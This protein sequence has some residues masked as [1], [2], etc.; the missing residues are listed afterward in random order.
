M[1]VRIRRPSQGA[2]FIHPSD[3]AARTAILA[4]GFRQTRLVRVFPQ[5]W[6]ERAKRFE[7]GSIAGPLEQLR[8]LARDGWPI[9]QAVVVFTYAGAPGISRPDR[10]CFWRVFGVPVFEQ[11]LSPKNKLLATECD[12]HVGLHVVSGCEGLP[13]EHDVCPCG[14]PAPRLTRGSRIEELAGLLA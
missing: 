7:P 4:A 8:T 10:D 11:Y 9:E 2:A 3:P 13:L 1:I 6:N 5:G 12:A 14:N